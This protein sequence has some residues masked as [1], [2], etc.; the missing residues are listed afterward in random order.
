[1]LL[2]R[3]FIIEGLVT[4]VTALVSTYFIPDWPEQ[5]RFLTASERAFV[6]S[7][8]QE[9][10]EDDVGRMDILD[11]TALKRIF[12]DWK[13]Y[14]GVFL[15]FSL[16][17]I[18]FSLALFTPTILSIHLQLT[19]VRSQILSIPVY[20]S[21]C[22]S[23][24]ITAILSDRF[25]H[26]YVFVLIGQAIALA[27]LVLLILPSKPTST[28]QNRPE[29]GVTVSA[30]AKYAALFL[31]SLGNFASFPLTLVWLTN[32]FSGHYKRGIGIA[33]LASLGACAGVLASNIFINK[34]AP[35]FRKGFATLLGCVGMVVIASSVY[36]AGLWWE[37][38]RRKKL[39]RLI[40][41]TMVGGVQNW[42]EERNKGDGD[43]RFRF[44]Y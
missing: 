34:D 38:R 7:R 40:E 44:V 15:Y 24:I 43:V 35:A 28:A 2:H 6:V 4:V 42:T 11:K 25:K 41:A 30:S 27:G 16:S 20:I 36:F 23:A 37:N 17:T 21:C 32:N 3:I 1:L 5:N 18:Q 33:A 22:V 8:I 13:I 10:A 29:T 14:V 39:R 12:C 19:A 31:T 26:R 9:S